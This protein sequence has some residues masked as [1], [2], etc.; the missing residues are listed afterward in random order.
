MNIL[1]QIGKLENLL[2]KC[3]YIHTYSASIGI[4]VQNLNRIEFNEVE[5]CSI[6]N[7]ASWLFE[8]IVEIQVTL[9]RSLTLHY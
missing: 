1:R 9:P 3:R 6:I 8:L 5:S 7:G 4:F 2:Y